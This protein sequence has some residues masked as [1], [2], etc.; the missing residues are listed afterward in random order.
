M[1]SYSIAQRKKAQGVN[2]WYGRLNDSDTGKTT[3]VSLRTTKKREAEMW[4]ARMNAERFFPELAKVPDVPM[5]DAVQAWLRGVE[6]SKGGY[7][8]TVE[9]YAF[10]LRPLA[11]WS[12]KNGIRNLAE[13]TPV[14]ANAYV[15]TLSGQAATTIRQKIV[16]IRS[17]FRWALD[18]YEIQKPNPMRTVKTPK[19]ENAKERHFWTPEQI[20]SIL[21][22]APSPKNRIFWALMAFAGLRKSEAIAVRP[23]DIRDGYLY[24][25]GKGAKYARVPISTRLRTELDR[26]GEWPDNRP[27][28]GTKMAEEVLWNACKRSQI[29][30][31]GKPHFH[32]FRHSFGT[33]LLRA[34]ATITEVQR[35]MRHSNVQ[36]TLAVYSH[37]LPEDLVR[38]VNLVK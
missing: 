8:K 17:F 25:T 22:A 15:A 18:T 19:N 11:E 10:H 1:R 3:Y 31:Q 24:L 35:L 38:A 4:L 27:Y 5:N 13:F 36:L 14:H 30:A 2:T 6:M 28:I 21:D 7:S 12:T 26:L 20:N 37:L 33:N 29:D 9:L 32:R 16:N 23:A 34:G